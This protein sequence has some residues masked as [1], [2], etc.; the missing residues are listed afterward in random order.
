MKNTSSLLFRQK[1]LAYRTSKKSDNT[2]T[3]MRHNQSTE[4]LKRA[5]FWT[6]F[7]LFLYTTEDKCVCS[8]PWLRS[9]VFKWDNRVK[10]MLSAKEHPSLSWQTKQENLTLHILRFP[11]KSV[12]P[13]QIEPYLSSQGMEI[14][15]KEKVQKLLSYIHTVLKAFRHQRH[16]QYTC[17][18]WTQTSNYWTYWIPMQSMCT[19]STQSTQRHWGR[20][21]PKWDSWDFVVFTKVF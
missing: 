16:E 21:W 14:T 20:G 3:N 19:Q 11:L 13:K 15:A 1:R 18:V 9:T 7:V 10:T 12:V 6:G 8:K 2:I 4:G 17:L 5:E